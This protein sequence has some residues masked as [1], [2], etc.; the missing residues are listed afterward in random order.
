MK[1]TL[2]MIVLVALAAVPAIYAQSATGTTT[3][4]VTV[5]DEASISI[6]AATTGLTNSAIWGAYTGSTGFHYSIRTTAVG[7]SGTIK[8]Q[9]DHALT[10]AGENTIPL[11]NLTYTS[12]VADGSVPETAQTASTSQ[13]D[14]ASFGTD[15]HLDNKTGTVSW[16]LTDDPAYKTGSYEAVATFTIASI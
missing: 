13:T 4:D 1:R 16:S 10:N 12:T 2:M 11:A 15:A 7:G 5:V 6:D 3:F 14:V 9:L 8:V